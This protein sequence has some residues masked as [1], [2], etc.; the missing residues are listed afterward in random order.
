MDDS[1]S[2]SS[3]PASSALTSQKIVPLL[4]EARELELQP[5]GIS[6]HVGS[7]ASGSR[8]WAKTVRALR[9]TIAELRVLGIV[10]EVLN[11]GGG[12]PCR[13]ASSSEAPTLEDESAGL[14][15]LRTSPTNENSLLRGWNAN[16]IRD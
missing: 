8:A 10:L 11:L 3:S 4:V 15:S 13:Y 5:Y 7:Q 6:F 12:F 2:S 1:G 14:W 9:P 16:L